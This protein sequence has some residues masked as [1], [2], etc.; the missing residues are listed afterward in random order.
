MAFYA[1]DRKYPEVLSFGGGVQ[2]SVLALMACK[3]ELHLDAVIFCDTG[4]E[5]ESTYETVEFVKAECEKASIPFWTAYADVVLNPFRDDAIEK[6]KGYMPLHEWYQSNGLLPMVRIPRCTFNWKIYPFRRMIQEKFKRKKK[7]YAAAWLGIT[8]DESHRARESEV[9]YVVNRFPLIDMGMSRK[10]CIKWL[11]DNYPEH[12]FSKSG[13]FMCM[14]Q[15]RQNWSSL[16]TN[17]PNLF[18]IA[19]T[20]EQAAKANGVKNA[21]LWAGRSIEAFNHDST[22]ADFGFEF[23]PDDFDCNAGGG[24]FL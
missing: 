16:K 24:C 6:I 4:S 21:G 11:A 13:C 5:M 20:M 2:S 19:L 3:E 17:H 14:Y 15:S 7:P 8:T 1:E 12:S 22:L 10:M 23:W 18:S 9:Q